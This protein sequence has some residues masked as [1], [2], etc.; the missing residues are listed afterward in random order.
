M[1]SI[2]KFKI[3]CSAI[4]KIMTNPKGGI[5]DAGKRT[6]KELQEKP[7]R[8][9]VQEKKLKELLYKLNNHELSQTAKSYCK[10]WLQEKVYD[11]KKQFSNKYT[12]KGLIVE[13]NS[14]DFIAEQQG[15]GILVKNEERFYS[16]YM[17]GE[18]DALLSQ[19]II[20]AKNSWDCFTFPLFESEIPN[21]DY[22][23]QG[24]GYMHLTKRK[25]YELIYVLSDTPVHLIKKEALFYA[26][27]NGYDEADMSIFNDFLK[28]MT[29]DDIDNK[30][31]IKVFPFKYDELAAINIE[32]R[33]ILCRK[34]IA[35]LI[36]TYLN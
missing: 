30:L 29:Y 27:S 36:K 3:R 33:V 9:A 32:N 1:N 6:I 16:E 22:W 12:Q 2:P 10:L 21:T 23:W 18:P 26:R 11:R 13:D 20:D 14:L 5:T 34:Y 8:T 17:E 31:K 4:G 35:L 28:K 15:H 24:Q 7:V 19:L 25:M